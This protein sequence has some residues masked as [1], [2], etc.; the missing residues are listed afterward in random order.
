M[1]WEQLD[2][3]FIKK[4]TLQIT[5]KMKPSD[6]ELVEPY[7]IKGSGVIY[8]YSPFQRTFVKIHRGAEVFIISEEEDDKERIL[9]FSSSRVIAISKDDIEPLGFN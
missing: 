7:K 6:G 1:A 9:A 4:L 5:G 2:K 3:S 8:C